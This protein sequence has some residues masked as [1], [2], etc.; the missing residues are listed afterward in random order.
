MQDAFGRLLL[1]AGQDKLAHL[2]VFHDPLPFVG[3]STKKTFGKIDV[4]IGAVSD[5]LCKKFK[6]EL[7]TIE[8]WCKDYQQKNAGQ[9]HA[10][11]TDKIPGFLEAIKEQ[12][13]TL[14]R[15]VGRDDLDRFAV[16]TKA[17]GQAMINIIEQHG[18]LVDLAFSEDVRTASAEIAN[19]VA[20]ERTAVAFPFV[21][22][23][24]TK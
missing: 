3:E 24:P 22:A 8:T 17:D 15:Y 21:P 11:V 2:G 9:K 13:A 19:G 16:V 6:G 10:V 7:E 18:K 12:K 23:P 4:C 5:L 14:D 20:D 1:L